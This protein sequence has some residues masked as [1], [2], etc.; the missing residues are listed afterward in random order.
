MNSVWRLLI[1]PVLLVG[2]SSSKPAVEESGP[3]EGDDTS[4][5][6]GVQQADSGED[7]GPLEPLGTLELGP[8]QECESP[9]PG[10]VYV[11]SGLDW[12]IDPEAFDP[13][14]PGGHEDGPSMAVGDVNLDGYP[15]LVILH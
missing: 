15:E 9:L 11:E 13:D 6:S 7:T 4:G 1:F 10:P 3:D 8:V 12:G 14:A 2:C 5:D